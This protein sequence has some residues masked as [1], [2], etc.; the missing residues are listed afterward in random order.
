MA[1]SVIPCVAVEMYISSY[2]CVYCDT[3]NGPK[4]TT[5]IE[6]TCNGGGGG[7]EACYK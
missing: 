7:G 4:L 5:E 6:A 1:T 3:Q 2:V